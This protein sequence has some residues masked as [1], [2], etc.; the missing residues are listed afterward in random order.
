M[1]K[2]TAAGLLFAL[3]AAPALFGQSIVFVSP[4]TKGL[5][6]MSCAA[7]SLTSFEELHYLAAARYLADQLCPKPVVDGGIG[8]WNGQAENSGMIDGCP[9][10]KAREIGAL[11]ARYYH[12]KAALVFDRNP[13]G[14]TALISFHVAQPLGI[15]SIM[16]AQAKVSGATVIPHPQDNEILFVATDP[17]QHERAI[18]LYALLHAHDLHEE[19]GNTELIGDNEDRTRARQVYQGILEQAPPQVK[20]LGEEIYTERFND[21]GLEP[22]AAPSEKL[23]VEKTQ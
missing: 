11:L 14:K 18:A 5:L 12:Q 1:R 3:T 16:M 9:N 2:L 20:Q 10:D 7:D 17:G 15:I 6:S 8:L 22:T 4:S 21:L 19:P 13:S 23:A